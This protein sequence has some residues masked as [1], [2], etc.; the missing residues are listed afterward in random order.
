MHAL[1][2]RMSSLGS[3]ARNLKLDYTVRFISQINN[4]F[5]YPLANARTEANDAKSNWRQRT[6][7][8]DVRRSMSL[9]AF[10][11]LCRSRLVMYTVAPRLASSSAVSRPI[12]LAPPVTR[13]TRFGNKIPMFSYCVPW[14]Y[15]LMW[16]LYNN[17]QIVLLSVCAYN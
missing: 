8:L 7:R 2:M 17:N 13:T 1:L 6:F 14:K 10:S 4:G 12:P 15:F 9:R 11:P 16:Y 3:S 5:I